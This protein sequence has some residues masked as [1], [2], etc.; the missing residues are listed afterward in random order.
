MEYM[1]RAAF[2]LVLATLIAAIVCLPT[3][4]GAQTKAPL[5]QKN[6]RRH[7]AGPLTAADF[8]GTAPDPQ[9]RPRRILALTTT[10]VKYEFQFS[11]FKKGGGLL[12]RVESIEVFAVVLRTQSWNAR[13]DDKLLLDH[14]QGHF[15]ITQIHALRAQAELTRLI[16]D[17]PLEATG[18]KESEVR[19]AIDR[20]IRKLLAPF[21][22][23][24]TQANQEYDSV[25]LHGTLP[26]RQ[27]EARK[28]QQELLK[29]WK[30]ESG[31]W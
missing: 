29:K 27:A 22:E 18:K 8:L 23:A 17:G 1:R 9:E 4:A 30:V 5:D 2:H 21:N 3:P 7:S 6:N 16:E 13:P 10:E 31:K 15:D 26:E 12:A 19:E 14:E 28:E 25:T 20:K 11:L 24:S